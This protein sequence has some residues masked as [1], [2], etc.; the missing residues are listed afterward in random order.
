[1]DVTWMDLD[2]LAFIRHIE[3]SFEL[4]IGW[5]AVSVKQGLDHCLWLEAE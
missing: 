2:L 4:Q 5:F 3:T 1:M